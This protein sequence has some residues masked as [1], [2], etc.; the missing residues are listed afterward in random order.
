MVAE[1]TINFDG[2]NQNLKTLSGEIVQKL[3]SQGY[4]TYLNNPTDGF[5]IQASKTG[6]PRDLI[7]A[8]RVFSILISGKP[9]DFSVRIGIGKLVQN[10]G[11]TAIEAV[12]LSELFLAVDVPEMLWTKHVEDGIAKDIIGIVG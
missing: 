9:N 5:V 8:D 2:K 11:V 3:Q 10:L 1:K 4:T 6:L 7:A 12:A